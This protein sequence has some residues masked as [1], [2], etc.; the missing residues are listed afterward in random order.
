MQEYDKLITDQPLGLI[1]FGSRVDI[2]IPKHDI[3]LLCKVCQELV[4]G[5]TILAKV[6]TQYPSK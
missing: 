6:K 2:E 5:R 4:G 3:N 1:K